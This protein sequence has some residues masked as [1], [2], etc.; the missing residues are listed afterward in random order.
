MIKTPCFSQ[1]QKFPNGND[2]FA[3]YE[4]TSDVIKIFDISDNL[5][6]EVYLKKDIAFSYINKKIILDHLGNTLFLNHKLIGSQK[7]VDYLYSFKEFEDLFISELGTIQKFR[8]NEL[9][10]KVETF[11]SENSEE[12]N[13]EDTSEFILTDRYPT[14]KR[15]LNSHYKINKEYDETSEI[16]NY[17]QHSKGHKEIEIY[18][19]FNKH[20]LV[21][22]LLVISIVNVNTPKEHKV[23]KYE[24][25][26]YDNQGN[27]KK[28]KDFITKSHKQF[29]DLILK[30]GKKFF[31][32]ILFKETENYFDLI[33]SETH[34]YIY[35]NE[36]LTCK[37]SI[38]PYSANKSVE[39]KYKYDENK[40]LIQIDTYQDDVN[41]E[42]EVFKYE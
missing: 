30:K 19:K 9:G 34:S 23:I 28:K 25:A 8:I 33:H 42:K 16:Y 1:K 2:I 10:L 17:S 41:T 5:V 20:D 21:S 4:K 22:D 31:L 3:F 27:L 24:K 32:E 39:Y 11:L 29:S 38:S 36:L 15:S 14:I 37:E 12:N 6:R 40:R 13:E 18:F 26:S 35:I 7:T